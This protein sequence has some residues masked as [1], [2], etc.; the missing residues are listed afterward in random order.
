VGRRLSSR[1][2]TKAVAIIFGGRKA[3][4]MQKGCG[5]YFGGRKAAAP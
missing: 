1:R 2:N 3:A 5:E 4:V